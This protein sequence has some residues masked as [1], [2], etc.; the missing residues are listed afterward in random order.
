MKKFVFLFTILIGFTLQA[1]VNLRPFSVGDNIDIKN[2]IAYMDN[3]ESTMNSIAAAICKD[4][5]TDIAV[6]NFIDTL[7]KRV[8]QDGRYLAFDLKTKLWSICKADAS[9]IDNS[10]WLKQNSSNTTIVPQ[11]GFNYFIYGTYAYTYKGYAMFVK[12]INL[13]TRKPVELFAKKICNKKAVFDIDRLHIPR[14]VVIEP[15]W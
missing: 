12:V 3:L 2:R 10:K 4:N 6:G 13:K 11:K 5:I 1:C 15:L 8:T 7:N 14:R 9:V